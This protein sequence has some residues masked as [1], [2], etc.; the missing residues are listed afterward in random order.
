MR[1]A[2]AG[3][4]SSLTLLVL[5]LTIGL[6]VMLRFRPGLWPMSQ[7]RQWLEPLIAGTG[8]SL[9]S[10][11]LYLGYGLAGLLL[12][13]WVWL[14]L[15]RLD[16]H[17]LRSRARRLSQSLE[18][19][20]ALE[21]GPRDVPRERAPDLAEDAVPA[22][23]S[24][25]VDKPDDERR[26]RLQRRILAL[27]ASAQEVRAAVGHEAAW[28]RRRL[29]RLGARRTMGLAELDRARAD[30]LRLGNLERQR[31]EQQAELAEH[32]EQAALRR[33]ACQ[34]LDGAA[35]AISERF[36]DHLRGMV[37]RALPQ[38]TEG[39]YDYLEVDEA[40]QV[41][42]YS[43][44]KRNLLDLDEIS[45]GTQRQILLAL[46]L[47]LSQELV[48][49]L[50]KDDQFAFLDEPFAFFDSTRLRGALKTLLELGGDVVQYWVVAQRFPQDT[51]IGIEIPCGRHPDTL[52]IGR[53]ETD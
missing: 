13:A 16:T 39:R 47:G 53:P 46:R 3:L 15:L 17:R 23:D 51:Y 1:R 7:L 29:A 18:S 45:S 9:E 38:F 40:F 26:A 6:W 35:R 8:L 52:E 43:S 30:R 42:V 14:A 5:L 2:A 37:S 24:P 49:R 44:D 33:L 36:S 34:L 4:L 19:I 31:D 11:V 12:L 48:S 41:R 27:D 50:V 21:P 22:E 25:P 32:R 28:M 20:E 10:T